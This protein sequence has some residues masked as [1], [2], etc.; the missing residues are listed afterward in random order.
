MVM[1]N[2]SSSELV[3]ISFIDMDFLTVEL[4]LGRCS[5]EVKWLR[6]TSSEEYRRGLEMALRIALEL[7]AELRKTHALIRS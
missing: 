4:D 5:A 6:Q 3:T 2:K 1:Q 7:R